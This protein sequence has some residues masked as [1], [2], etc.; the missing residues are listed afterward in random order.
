MAE[1]IE[2][3]KKLAPAINICPPSPEATYVI[4][5]AVI[6]AAVNST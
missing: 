1:M 5:K 3:A 4:S 6:S 2:T